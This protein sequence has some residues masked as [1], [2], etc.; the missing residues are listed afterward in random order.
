[1]QIKEAAGTAGDF[2][3]YFFLYPAP[4]QVLHGLLP[5]VNLT[6]MISL[7]LLFKCCAQVALAC[8]PQQKFN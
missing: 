7:E 1:M 6:P 3:F 5:G 4:F 8:M 2:C